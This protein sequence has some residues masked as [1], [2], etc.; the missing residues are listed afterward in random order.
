MRELLGKFVSDDHPLSVTVYLTFYSRIL[1]RIRREPWKRRRRTSSTNSRLP[2]KL[3]SPPPRA[4]TPQRQSPRTRKLR[5]SMPTRS[6]PWRK[7]ISRLQLPPQKLNGKRD[8]QNG[9][10][11][12]RRRTLNLQK[13]GQESRNWKPNSRSFRTLV[14]R[15][16]RGRSLP[17]LLE[18]PLQ[19]SL[20]HRDLPPP[21][22]LHR[23]PP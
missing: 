23:N 14:P 3:R 9:N 21:S 7:R 4:R 13:C 20:P 5:T 6:R 2:S 8:R 22:L 16:L 19:P 1:S 18:I 11:N 10:S 17:L 15:Q 12:G